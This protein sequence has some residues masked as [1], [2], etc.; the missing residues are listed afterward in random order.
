MALYNTVIDL[1][2][3]DSIK[4]ELDTEETSS[5]SKEKATQSQ[6]VLTLPSYQDLLLICIHV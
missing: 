4:K 6:Y 5:Q 1:T 3:E 2:Q